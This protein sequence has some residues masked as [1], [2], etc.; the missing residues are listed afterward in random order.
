MIHQ[1]VLLYI[2]QIPSTS[3]PNFIT[4]KFE[5]RECLQEI[6]NHTY[7]TYSMSSVLLDYL[8]TDQQGGKLLHLQHNSIE[9]PK[10]RFS[11]IKIKSQEKV[12]KID[13]TIT[14]D[15]LGNPTKS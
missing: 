12:H 13:K 3:R 2:Y 8:L 5:Y 11:S 10:K 15:F 14:E 7:I 6:R 1:S 9:N 4:K